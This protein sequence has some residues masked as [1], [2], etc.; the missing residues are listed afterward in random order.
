MC[1]SVIISLVK[2]KVHGRTKRVLLS[3]VGSDSELLAQNNSK[4]RKAGWT[5]GSAGQ[6]VISIESNF[7]RGWNDYTIER[8]KP[9]KADEVLLAKEYKRC[10]G[11][12]RALMAHVK[13]RGFDESLVGL[14]TAKAAKRYREAE[15]KLW[16]QYIEVAAPKWERY[17]EAK[18]PAWKQYKDLSAKPWIELFEEKINRVKQ[19]R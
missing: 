11:S 19:L 3:G 13:R 10:A 1:Q 18:V 16:K 15:A 17:E 2:F 14:L 6:E 7:T 9:S 12:A 5:E 8:G 4:L